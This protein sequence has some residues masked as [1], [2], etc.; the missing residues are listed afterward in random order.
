MLHADAGWRLSPAFDLIPNIGF[1]R[2]HVL[3]IGMHARPPNA[4]TLLAEAKHFGIKRRRQAMNVIAEIP[5][6][7]LNC[8][9]V[10]TIPRNNDGDTGRF[11]TDPIACNKRHAV[12]KGCFGIHPVGPRG[13]LFIGFTGT[14]LPL[15]CRILSLLTLFTSSTIIF[16]TP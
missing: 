10:C 14:N 13:D 5:G 2:E 6:A 3:R 15:P 16:T 12:N 11:E 8:R 1:N 4:A 9:N 7:V